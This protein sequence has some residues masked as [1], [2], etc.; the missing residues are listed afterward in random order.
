MVAAI[1]KRIRMIL[2]S[3]TLSRIS[4]LVGVKVA[5]SVACHE[6]ALLVQCAGKIQFDEPRVQTRRSCR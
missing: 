5:E 3:S 1:E 2:D 4:R 6:H